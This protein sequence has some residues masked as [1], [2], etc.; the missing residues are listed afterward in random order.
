MDGTDADKNN[1]FITM[2]GGDSSSD[3]TN[4]SQV[5]IQQNAITGLSDQGQELLQIN[6]SDENAQFV[7]VVYWYQM[8]FISYNFT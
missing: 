3:I 6:N 1:I 5:V 4:D 2:L 8:L 7:Q